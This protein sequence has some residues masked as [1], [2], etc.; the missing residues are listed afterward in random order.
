LARKDKMKLTIIITVYNEKNTILQAIED[1]KSVAIDK[2]IIII[3]NCSTDGT[4][5]ILKNLPPDS[6]IKIIFQPENYGYGRSV[7]TGAALARGEYMYIQYSDLE[8]DIECVYRMT[9]AAEKN[10]L[11]AVLGSRLYNE[12]MG[13]TGIFSIIKKRPYYLGTLI[14]TFLINLLYGRKFTDIIGTRFYRTASFKKLDLKSDNIA[15]DFE[16]AG[17]M[18]VAGFNIGEIPVLYKARKAREGKKVKV[19]DIIPAVTAILRTKIFG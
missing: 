8:Y 16:L 18:C 11:D 6:M 9:D 3:D 19:T 2:E 4:R 10:N 5:E 15:F 14:T 7:K 13:I 12:R 17:R 1:A